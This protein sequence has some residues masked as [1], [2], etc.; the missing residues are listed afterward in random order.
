MP[1]ASHIILFCVY[2]ALAIGA[3]AAAPSFSD[4]PPVLIGAVVFLACALAH[5]AWA[6]RTNEARLI[7]SMRIM[8]AAYD[9]LQD[10]N[11][12]HPPEE[13]PPYP[14]TRAPEPQPPSPSA[15]PD[16]GT[17]APG[18]ER[19]GGA[20]PQ[21]EAAPH[22]DANPPPPSPPEAQPEPQPVNERGEIALLQRL[23][24]T[25]R[26]AEDPGLRPE[27]GIEEADGGAGV[28][29]VGRGGLRV[30]GGSDR[31]DGEGG[32][33]LELV[34]HGLRDDR[35]DLYLQPI[36]SLP[37]RKRRFFECYSRVRTE[38]GT[39]IE[40]SEYLD[41]AKTAGLLTSIDNILLFRCL[42]LLGKLQRQDTTAVFFCNVS[43]YTLADDGFVQDIV[44]YMERHRELSA[45]LV[46]EMA[47]SDLT[48]APAS[49]PDYLASLQAAGYR[50]SMDG[51]RDLDLDIQMMAEKG[52]RSVK[53]DA[54]ILLELIEAGRGSVVRSLKQNL[55]HH[56]IDMIVERIESEKDLLELLDFNIDYGQGFL[57]G[58]PRP[59]KDP[60]A[61]ERAD[62]SG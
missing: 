35:V 15:P 2:A 30:V 51:V 33:V 42:Q 29:G 55:D 43:A 12:T 50:F 38:D 62:G 17:P 61:Q 21:A 49:L 46:L 13:P 1:S 19:P 53:I 45:K 25:L 59:G 3:G 37:Q 28:A 5:E 36:V 34:E 31:P 39:V 40:P 11:P 47:Q 6:R 7:R 48:D 32:T 4:A 22:P 52:F 9:R 41:L 44:A 8:K 14:S 60:D 56:G 57:F 20:P 58:E 54:A 18:P 10:P 16:G 27:P 24:S 23:L 26:S